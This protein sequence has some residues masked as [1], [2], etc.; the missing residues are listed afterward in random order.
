LK[1]IPVVLLSLAIASPAAAQ[2]SPRPEPQRVPVYLSLMGEP[3]R[4]TAGGPRPLSDWFAVADRDQDGAVSLAEMLE[5]ASR[6]FKILDVDRDGV[7]N[8]IEMSRYEREIA[9]ARVRFDGGL[10]P[11][12]SSDRSDSVGRGSWE[13][14][15]RDGRRSSSSISGESRRI[16]RDLQY[17]EVPQ[18][19]MMADSDFNQRV[20]AGEFAKMGARRFAMNDKNGDGRL[21]ASELT[22]PLDKKGRPVGPGQRW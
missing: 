16:L 14:P 11:V 17:L 13:D 10:K 12:R 22:S 20:T 1:A 15:D 5:D 9:P 8:T 7:I 6:F 19:V 3:F 21:E 4:G 2:T 18:P